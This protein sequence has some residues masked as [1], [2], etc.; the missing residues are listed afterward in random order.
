MKIQISTRGQYYVTIPKQL[1]LAKGFNKGDKVTWQLDK[2]GD[3]VLR[4]V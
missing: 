4:K 1:A 3:L 2:K